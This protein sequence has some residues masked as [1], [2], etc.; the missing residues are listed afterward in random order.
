MVRLWLR[1]EVFEFGLVTFPP[2]ARVEVS[3][4]Y[5]LAAT[6]RQTEQARAGKLACL[7]L[8]SHLI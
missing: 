8:L 2:Q 3:T 7:C 6:L 4:L 1:S 5:E